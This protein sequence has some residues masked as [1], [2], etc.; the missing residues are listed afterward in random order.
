MYRHALPQGFVLRSQRKEMEAAE[1]ANE[2]SLEEFL[3]TARHQLGS[4]LTPVTAESFAQWKKDRLNKK[5]AEEEAI[6][7]KKKQQAQANKML[8]LS[9][10]EMFQLNPEMYEDADEGGAGDE[11]DMASYFKNW[12]QD[13][14]SDN[15][16]DDDDD[17]NVQ[18]TKDKL[19]DLEI[20]G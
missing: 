4:N 17:E 6:E 10:R 2:I 11:F 3:E 7:S 8:G 19:K 15:G 16:R 9:G 18:E 5:Q 20:A 1:K 13:R 14:Q 12:E